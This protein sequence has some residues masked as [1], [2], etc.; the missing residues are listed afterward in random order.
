MGQKRN[1]K[2]STIMRLYVDDKLGLVEVGRQVGLSPAGVAYR[3]ERMG[4]DRRKPAGGLS[5]GRYAWA[6]NNGMV[7]VTSLQAHSG[8]RSFKKIQDTMVELAIPVQA[9]GGGSYVTK[10]DADR[11]VAKMDA[12][13]ELTPVPWKRAKV[14]SWEMGWLGGI[15]DGE[16]HVGIALK[17]GRWSAGIAVGS[18][19]PILLDKVAEILERLEVSFTRARVEARERRWKDS[20]VLRVLECVSTWRLC[21]EAGPF[22]VLK[23][24]RLRLLQEFSEARAE[25]ARRGGMLP[26]VEKFVAQMAVVE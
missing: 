7:S 13:Y 14:K 6:R 2:D 3:L 23:G 5:S 18:T 22:A 11:V 15:I 26:V 24:G 16:A 1:V 12:I 8:G 21:R 20:E 17:D 9:Q 25:N 4:V 10:K 19:T